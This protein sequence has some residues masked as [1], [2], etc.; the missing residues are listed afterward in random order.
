MGSQ[1]FLPAADSRAPTEHDITR[2]RPVCAA[3]ARR[4]SAT[5]APQP[6]HVLIED[7][8]QIGSE[9]LVRYGPNHAHLLSRAIFDMRT[10]LD[11][12]LYGIPPGTERKHRASRLIQA[13]EWTPRDAHRTTR[14]PEAI[15]ADR[16]RHTHE[17]GCHRSSSAWGH[18]TGDRNLRAL[19]RDFHVD[20]LASCEET[21]PCLP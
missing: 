16:E 21:P 8:L 4:L 14:T 13:V 6:S 15:A 12:W 11:T 1:V 2:G 17:N 9:A 20:L 10:F 3:V 19:S 5:R 18:Q 7:L